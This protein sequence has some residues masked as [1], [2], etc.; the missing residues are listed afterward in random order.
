M[1]NLRFFCGRLASEEIQH[2]LGFAGWKEN[3]AAGWIV[4]T[5]IIEITGVRREAAPY[6]DV[7]TETGIFGQTFGPDEKHAT[8]ENSQHSRAAYSG[9]GLLRVFDS[10]L[11]PPTR[12]SARSRRSASDQ[13]SAQLRIFRR[14]LLWR[15]YVYGNLR[16][17]PSGSLSSSV[18]RPA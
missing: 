7:L 10:S 11:L 12:P 13:F 6:I 9:D 4:S 16:C 15:C 18:T 14:R 3:Q 1:Q 8:T 17:I 5:V 2:T